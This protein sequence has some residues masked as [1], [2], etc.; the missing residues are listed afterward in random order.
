MIKTLIDFV[1]EPEKYTKKEIADFLQNNFQENILHNEPSKICILVVSETKIKSVA[2]DL[3][4]S[5]AELDR[6]KEALSHEFPTDLRLA[7][8]HHSFITEQVHKHKLDKVSLKK[9]SKSPI[10]EVTTLR[11]VETTSVPMNNL[12][13]EAMRDRRYLIDENGLLTEVVSNEE[14]RSVPT[15]TIGTTNDTYLSYM[16]RRQELRTAMA[17]AREELRRLH[18]I[19]QDFIDSCGVAPSRLEGQINESHHAVIQTEAEYL[20]AVSPR[21]PENHCSQ[22]IPSPLTPAQEEALEE[23]HQETPWTPVR[24]PFTEEV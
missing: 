10:P 18:Q 3:D 12:Y 2:N 6:I 22:F 4:L 8:A 1:Y 7:A 5:E 24:N 11:R 21:R 9:I 13:A 19:R 23:E 17:T 16:S 20:A 14:V 15:S